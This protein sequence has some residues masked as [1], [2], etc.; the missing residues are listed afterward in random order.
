MKQDQ[1]FTKDR[2]FFLNSSSQMLKNMQLMK[3]VC[4]VTLVSEDNE[5]IR[6]HNLVLAPVITPSGTIL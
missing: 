6:A 1:V 4:D 5:R 2:E 3:E